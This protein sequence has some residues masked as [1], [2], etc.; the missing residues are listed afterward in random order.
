MDRL[1][2]V[3][4]LRGLARHKLHAALNIGGLA[5]GIAVFLVL[6]LYVRFETGYE[7]WLPHYQSIHLIEDKLDSDIDS[8]PNHFTPIAMW[9]A[10]HNDLP[11][12][13]GTRITPLAAT[14]LRDGAGA[15]ESF[16]YVDPDFARVFDLPMVQ[17]AL[18][19]AFDD[20]ANAVITRAVAARYFPDGNATGKTMTIVFRGEKHVFRVAGIMQDLPA[21]TGLKIGI[22]ARTVIPQDPASAY[23]TPTHAW[24][25]FQTLTYVRLN[26]AASVAA[27]D[28]Q[29]AAVVARHARAETPGNPTMVMRTHL[30]PIADVFFETPGTRLAVRTL[31]TV[32]V[33]TLLIAV[34]NYVNLATARAGLRAREVAMRKVLG[35][36]QRTLARQYI[37]EAVATTA[38]AALFGLALAEAGLPLVN[39]AGG[40]ALSIQ[41]LG[42][43]GVLLPLILLVLVV[44]TLA[45]IYPALVLSRIPAAAVLASARSPGGGKAGTRIREGLVIVQFT[46]AIAFVVGTMVLIAQTRHVRSSDL[47]FDRSGLILVPS[48]GNSSLNDAQRDT[49]LHRFATLPGVSDASVANNAPG[50]DAF[51]AETNIALPGVAGKGPTLRFFETTP[52]FFKV[53]GAR[54]LAGRV[55]DLSH[56]GDVNPNIADTKGDGNKPNVIVINKAA[57]T[58][59]HF[60][61]PQSAIGQ[62]VGGGNGPLRTIIGVVDD[63]RFGDPRTAIPP[64]FYDFQPRDPELAIAILRYSGEAQPVIDA[65][66]NVWRQEAPEVPFDALTATQN[67]EDFYKQDDHAAHLFTVGAVLA[68]AIGCVGLWGLASF[69]TARRIKE[70]GIR[71]VLGASSTDVV[72]LL[73]GQFL[74]PVLIAN[75]FAWPLAFFAMRVWLAGFDDRIALS[76]LY[77]VA[78]SALALGIASLTVLA[79]SLRAARAAPAWALRHE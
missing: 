28:N 44:G 32:G 29:L 69:N 22:L 63:M 33:L 4:F 8:R 9:S 26:D 12:T 2:F 3:A 23:H 31:G 51:G 67:I 36:D 34:V 13:I 35:A 18:L 43:Q 55:F 70:I 78:A 25:Y 14:V 60:T 11:A 40:L 45:G 65:A 10:I 19:H 79:Q 72:R 42:L 59:L 58:A 24:N 75:L 27:F 15:K 39:A 46:I 7:T 77:F 1:T 68:I 62:T 50:P 71:K 57:M 64:M 74:R 76:P 38:I 30:Q 16:A 37:G 47:G 56:P 73:V 21:D 54:L 48:L 20:P 52:G 53:V 49:I 5:V 17:G 61:S 41:Y 66:R 6:G